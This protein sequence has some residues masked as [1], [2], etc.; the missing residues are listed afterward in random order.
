M[1]TCKVCGE[2]KPYADFGKEP[3]V[4]D[5]LQARCKSCKN[6]ANKNW[7]KANPDK[8]RLSVANW[9]INNP[10]KA[11]EYQNRYKADKREYTRQWYQENKD[12]YRGYL[13]ARRAK[14]RLNDFVK[15]SEKEVL[16]TY[17]TS[18]HLCGIAI[19]MSA[20]RATG[21]AGWEMGLQIDHIIPIARGGADKL[22]NVK[23]AHGLC[24]IKKGASEIDYIS[25]Q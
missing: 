25:R 10:D 24:N 19:D 17:G 3:R 2:S 14:I 16:D 21:K 13:R 8:A 22:E 23:P 7:S 20:P 5:G 4:A 12:K 15:Y 6:E 18:C 11:I 1:K 9:R